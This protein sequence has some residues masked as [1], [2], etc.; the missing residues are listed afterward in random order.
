MQMRSGFRARAVLITCASRGWPASGCSTFGRLE[1]MRLPWPAARMTT[2]TRAGMGTEIIAQTWVYLR[3][4][5]G[6]IDVSDC[7][8]RTDS[9]LQV[10]AESVGVDASGLQPDLRAPP[11]N[12]F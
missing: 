10:A 9:L 1:C 3:T 8:L 11:Q 2:L 4:A 5:E 12:V 6:I 7:L